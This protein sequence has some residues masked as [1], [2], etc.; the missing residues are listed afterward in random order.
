M[1]CIT[2]RRGR[3]RVLFSLLSMTHAC[4][5]ANSCEDQS[6]PPSYVWSAALQSF[7]SIGATFLTNVLPLQCTSPAARQGE[8]L[9]KQHAHLKAPQSPHAASVTTPP[10]AP[11]RGALHHA[12]NV[13]GA[14]LLS[15]RP[16]SSATFARSQSSPPACYGAPALSNNA[17]FMALS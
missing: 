3:S 10:R 8:L 7:R 6:G 17:N 15:M 14:D 9:H 12:M 16:L 5:A 2:V 11:P 1:I 4:G 13:A